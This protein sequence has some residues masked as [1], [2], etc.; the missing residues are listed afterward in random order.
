M[1][2]YIIINIYYNLI[3]KMIIN[4]LQQNIVIKKMWVSKILKTK[5]I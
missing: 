2:I 5:D 1:G 3:D 4:F